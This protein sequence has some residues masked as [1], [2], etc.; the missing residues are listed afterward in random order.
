MKYK[1]IYK[2]ITSVICII[3]FSKISFGQLLKQPASKAFMPV[4]LIE[5]FSSEGCSSCPDADKFL[6]ELIRVADSAE[7]PVYVIDFHVDVWNRSGWVDKYSDTLNT[8]RQIN[9]IGKMKDIP[10]YTPQS[11]LN[12]ILSVPGSDKKSIA[13]FIKQSLAMPRANFLKINAYQT[14]KDTIIIEYEIFGN[15]DSLLINFALVE[16]DIYTKVTAGENAGKLLHHHN[17]VRAFKTEKV[18]VNKGTAFMLVPKGFSL[19]QSRVTSYIQHERTWFV[20]GADQ[21]VN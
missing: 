8:I 17:V 2:L 3:L 18:K 19:K 7:Q 14:N 1:I 5:N 6:G 20:T 4:V 15:T 11:F 16:N 9:Y 13:S 12:G 21:L 10:M